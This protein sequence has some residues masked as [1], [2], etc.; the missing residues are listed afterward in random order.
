MLTLYY[1]PLSPNARRVWVALLEK[2]LDF[3]LE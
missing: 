3:T 2:Q 1:S